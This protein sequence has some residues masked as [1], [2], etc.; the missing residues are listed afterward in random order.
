M[1]HEFGQTEGSTNARLE[2]PPAIAADDIALFGAFQLNRATRTLCKDNRP[3]RLGS[4]A[5]EILLALTE[6]AGAV[7]SNR[8]LLRR[9]WP[10]TIVEE[11]TIRVHV[12]LLRKTLREA[13]PGSDYVQNVTGRGYRFAAVITKQRSSK[14]S[15]IAHSSSSTVLQLP[16]RQPSRRNNLPFLLTPVF[17]YT[18]TARMLVARVPHERL[19]TITGPGGSGKSTMAIGVAHALVPRYSHGVCYIDLASVTRPEGVSGALAATLGVSSS[20]ADPLPEI[21]ASLSK[22]SLLLVLDNCEHVIERS[23]RIAECLLRSAPQVHVLATSREPLRASGEVALQLTQLEGSEAGEVS[24]CADLMQLPA[25]RLFVERANT[26]ASC[27]IDD[28]DL[29]LVANVCQRLAGN[30][31]AIEIAAAQVHWLGVRALATTLHDS[32][33]L[34]M[35]GRR[36]AEPRHRTL[37]ASCD[38]SYNLLTPDEQTVF[39]R[40]SVFAG[41][42]DPDHGAAVIADERLTHQR[43]FECLINLAR[44]SLLIRDSTQ[45]DIRYRLQ[46][47]SRAY[48]R[49]KLHEAQ[50][51]ALIHRRHS[52]MR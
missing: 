10:H 39:R 46:D 6:R 16:L 5:M 19:M 34:S 50:E 25:V 49:E 14:D 30:A 22:Q 23:A 41:S 4:R 45:G 31:L 35:D 40:L 48:A 29:P 38:W 33:Y 13:E 17:G 7:L 3:V 20:S 42:F 28:D 12:A 1:K 15:V 47:F 24:S 2:H 32:F 37:R 18:Q 36:T 27:E 44:K 21:L 8:D 26:H 11:G 52:Q 43:V 9:V 51:P